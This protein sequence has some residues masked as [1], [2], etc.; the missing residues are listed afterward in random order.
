MATLI[1]TIASS[2][3]PTIGFAQD[4]SKHV[5]PAWAPIFEAFAPVKAW[6]AEK[7]PDVLLVIYNDH[8]TSF[9]FDHYSP[10][11]LG[12]GDEYRPADEGGGPRRLPS[13]RGHS[14]LAAMNPYVSTTLTDVQSVSYDSSYVY[15]KHTDVPSYDIG[16]TDGNNPGY[17]SN[18]NK[19]TRITRT[20]TVATTHAATPQ[21]PI[22]VMANGGLLFN[23]GDARSYNNAGT[24]NQN[25][26]VVEASTYDMGPGHSAPSNTTPPG[27][28]TPGVYHYHES[29]T[30]LINQIDPGNTGQH[31][32]PIIGYAFDGK[33]KWKVKATLEAGALA[34]ELVKGKRAA[35][36]AETVA[37]LGK[38]SLSF[39]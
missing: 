16:R 15:I 7:K 39:R 18:Q 37:L 36:P 8:V 38:R 3:T 21:G 22:G 6:L 27:S 4:A 10:F 2:H 32:S 33:Q 29:P 14:A 23:P 20:P 28:T 11:V 17:A 5:D 31:R 35:L 12:I 26:N 24:W 25:A 13:V 1:G 34:L 30:A 9:F 19:V